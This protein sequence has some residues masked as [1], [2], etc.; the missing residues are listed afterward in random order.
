MSRRASRVC[1][2]TQTREQK[3]WTDLNCTGH[4]EGVLAVGWTDLGKTRNS[5]ALANDWGWERVLWFRDDIAQL[6]RPSIY[7]GLKRWCSIWPS[8]AGGRRGVR[9]LVQRNRWLSPWRLLWR[10]PD[11]HSMV[12]RDVVKRLDTRRTVGMTQ[13]RWDLIW[14]TISKGE[15]CGG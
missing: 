6:T 9:V 14:S 15:K 12:R 10:S 7:R 4:D 13:R 3:V 8:S 2:I 11:V 1:E 5:W